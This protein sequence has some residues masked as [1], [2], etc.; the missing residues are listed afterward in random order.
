MESTTMKKKPKNDNGVSHA[1]PACVQRR[2]LADLKSH[3][4]QAQVFGDLPDHELQALAA[5]IK[6]KGLRQQIEV[7]A[8]GTILK[9]HQ[10]IRA[11]RLN[12]DKYFDVLVRHDLVDAEPNVIEREFLEDNQYRRHVTPL[13]KARVAVRLLEIERGRDPGSLL[14][15]QDEE[16]RDRAGK[17]LG[18]SGRTLSRYLLVLRTPLE[19]QQAFEN[20]NLS[21]VLVGKVA[22]LNDKVQQTVAERLRRGEE[23]KKLVA[24]YAKPQSNRHVKSGDAFASFVRVLARG[25][26]DL[27]GRTDKISSK[28]IGENIGTLKKARAMLRELWDRRPE[29]GQAG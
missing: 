5:D 22:L 4:L 26:E 25:L 28:A 21:L 12:G 14:K 24:E 11:L 27:K 2:K 9:G 18:M 6:A 3:P 17:A 16:S 15:G 29:K 8:D 23:P 1:Q 19:V 13:A 10:R 7:L 20:G